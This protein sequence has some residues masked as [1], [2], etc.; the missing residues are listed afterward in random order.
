MKTMLV[1]LGAGLMLVAAPAVLAQSKPAAKPAAAA[2]K[3]PTADEKAIDRAVENYKKNK[4][5]MDA[6]GAKK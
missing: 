1:A 5:A 3:G 2:P 4:A 6:K